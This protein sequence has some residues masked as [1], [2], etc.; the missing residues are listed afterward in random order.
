MHP[1]QQQRVERAA[2]GRCAMSSIDWD[3]QATVHAA[4][5]SAIL[6]LALPF[7]SLPDEVKAM[8]NDPARPRA[9]EPVDVHRLAGRILAHGE[10]FTT[11]SLDRPERLTEDEYDERAAWQR[12]RLA[13]AGFGAD[14]FRDPV[15]VANRDGGVTTIPPDYV[16]AN[17]DVA[18]ERMVR[19]SVIAFLRA[20]HAAINALIEHAV[21]EDIRDE[22]DE[23][24]ASL[25]PLDGEGMTKDEY[26]TAIGKSKRTAETTLRRLIEGGHAR[27]EEVPTAR[28]GAKRKV[29]YRVARGDDDAGDGS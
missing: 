26:A 1:A 22:R 28:G 16:D 14:Y 7:E 23:R 4:M 27:F 17:H 2:R 3:P 13:E 5:T 20:E 15:R 6:P 24:A 9:V 18:Y 19:E 12:R 10:V 25:L 29:F 21:I 11:R 8:L